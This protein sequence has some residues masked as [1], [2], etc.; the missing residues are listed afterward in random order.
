MRILSLDSTITAFKLLGIF[1]IVYLTMM[2]PIPQ[3]VIDEGQ[4]FKNIF[5]GYLKF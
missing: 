5:N 2:T 3:L 1:K 4:K